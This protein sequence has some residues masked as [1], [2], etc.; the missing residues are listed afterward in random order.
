[1]I[2]ISGL[3]WNTFH[4]SFLPILNSSH[5]RNFISWQWRGL[6][7]ILITNIL[8]FFTEPISAL[9]YEI[10]KHFLRVLFLSWVWFVDFII[11]MIW[12]TRLI[13]RVVVVLDQI[14]IRVIHRNHVILNTLKLL[15]T[16][17]IVIYRNIIIFQIIFTRFLLFI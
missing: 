3:W 4:P 13:I 14:V 9:F 5:L 8:T 7:L 11:L 2:R 17:L 12:L 10:I 6:L 1:M 16:H 15:W